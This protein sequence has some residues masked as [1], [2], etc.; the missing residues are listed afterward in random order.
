VAH[1]TPAVSRTERD[2][3]TPYA[4]AFAAILLLI[5]QVPGCAKEEATMPSENLSIVQNMYADVAAGDREAFFAVLDPKVEWYLAEG[6]PFEVRNPYVGPAAIGEMMAH[7][8]EFLQYEHEVHDFFDAGDVIVVRGVYHAVYKPKNAKFTTP[9]IHI[10]WL[11]QGKIVKF[12][13][14]V[15]TALVEHAF[16]GRE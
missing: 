2:V 16:E 5:F 10:L 1:F 9:F 8:H 7:V 4:L 3:S 14:H 12:E 15:D 13:Q 6:S 11:R